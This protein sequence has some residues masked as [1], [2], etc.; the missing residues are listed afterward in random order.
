M[1]EDAN[2][3][4]SDLKRAA[5]DMC[6]VLKTARCYIAR[7]EIA[8][9]FIRTPLEVKIIEVLAKAEGK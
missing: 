2:P 1:A 7:A 4:L 5:P 6:E 9:G 8:K 3:K